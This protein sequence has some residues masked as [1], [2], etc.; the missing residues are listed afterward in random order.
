MAGAFCRL[1]VVVHFICEVLKTVDGSVCL[2]V[3]DL[4]G[5]WKT[6]GLILYPRFKPL[7]WGRQWYFLFCL[8]SPDIVCTQLNS[9]TVYSGI[10]NLIIM[11]SISGNLMVL[12]FMTDWRT[13]NLCW[14]YI[15][16]KYISTCLVVHISQ[17]VSLSLYIFCCDLV[18]IWI[19]FQIW[20]EQPSHR[21]TC[22]ISFLFTKFYT[23]RRLRH[24]KNLG[25][26][27]Y[28]SIL[29]SCTLSHCRIL[30]SR[31]LVFFS[32]SIIAW[33][34]CNFS[35]CVKAF[36][37]SCSSLSSWRA[38]VIKM[39]WRMTIQQRTHWLKHILAIISGSAPNEPSCGPGISGARMTLLDSK[40][41]SR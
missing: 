19:T 28:W 20:P 24:V 35:G 25:L 29:P 14:E 31:F 10:L 38:K 11:V 6:G 9:T 30:V 22:Q 40:A 7:H 32:S 4:E 5:L 27:R 2:R 21:N 13:A 36:N 26:S 33:R 8:H 12:R 3:N 37:S 15:L 17:N 34:G 41:F 39:L 16:F 23:Y 18:T 1:E